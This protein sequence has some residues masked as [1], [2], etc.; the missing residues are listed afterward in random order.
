ME[1]KANAA[2]TACRMISSPMAKPLRAVGRA[3]VGPAAFLFGRGLRRWTWELAG[4]EVG[5]SSA[6]D[7]GLGSS[8][9]SEAW[10]GGASYVAARVYDE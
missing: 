5:V 6:L 3:R 2:N 9:R 4:G 1:D 10:K 7:H 8:T